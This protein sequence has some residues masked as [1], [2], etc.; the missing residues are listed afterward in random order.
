VPRPETLEGRT[1]LSRGGYLFSTFDAPGAGTNGAL[2]QAT[3]VLGINA[4]GSISG[5]YGTSNNLTHGFLLRDGQYTN[6]DDPNAGKGPFQGTDALGL[7]NE[8]DVVGVYLDQS[9]VT[10]GFL[11]SHG[12]YATLDDPKAGTVTGA[13]SLND[14]GQIV[15]YYVDASNVSHGFLLSQ[16]QYTT[17]DNPNAGTGASQGTFAG[18]INASGDIVGNYTDANGAIH[19]FLATPKHRDVLF[20]PAG[21]T[22]GIMSMSIAAPTPSNTT[23]LGTLVVSAAGTSSAKTS[24]GSGHRSSSQIAPVVRVPN[25]PQSTVDPGV[26]VNGARTLGAHLSG[27]LKTYV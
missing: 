2:G 15:G 1:L 7:N 26:T 17:L 12:Q 14:S 11:L 21:S 5:N 25:P 6:L 20:G 18:G 10:H 19:G 23:F 4:S 27:G 8:G 22:I 3:F 24:D 13:W 9:S 16:G